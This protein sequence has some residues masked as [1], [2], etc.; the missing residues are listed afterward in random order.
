MRYTVILVWTSG[1]ER[2]DAGRSL[3]AAKRIARLLWIE[4]HPWRVRIED[5]G[6]AI[7]LGMLWTH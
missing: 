5:E 7:G 6:Q 3:A 1:V 4:R 2:L